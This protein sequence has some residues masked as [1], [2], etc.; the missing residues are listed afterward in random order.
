MPQ[1][2]EERQHQVD[3]SVS[4]GSTRS[5]FLQ[6]L[7]YGEHCQL[8]TPAPLGWYHPRGVLAGLEQFACPFSID[9]TYTR[10][11]F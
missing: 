1:Q 9:H 8:C 6:P 4:I 11:E 2:G 10:L 3:A 5:L 7:P